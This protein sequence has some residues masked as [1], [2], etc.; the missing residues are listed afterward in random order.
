MLRRII[1]PSGRRFMTAQASQ[2]GRK[3]LL[4][5]RR[6]AMDLLG[7][8]DRGSGFSEAEILDAFGKKMIESGYKNRKNA[9]EYEEGGGT[10]FSREYRL[11][12]ASDFLL[13]ELSSH[14]STNYAAHEEVINKLKQQT[15]K[16]TFDHLVQL[17]AK[18]VAACC[19]V[20]I[21]SILYM[22]G[23]ECFTPTIK[24][25][26]Y[27][28]MTVKLAGVEKVTHHP[29][30]NSIDGDGLANAIANS[31]SAKAVAS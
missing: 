19:F 3:G 11:R 6:I 12:K 30:D 9:F 17:G 14:T 1:V 27:S 8:S 15:Q 29:S 31:L 22:L 2:Q 4:M 5:N 13:N 7:L 21:T 26:A 23:T 10:D 28:E 20:L 24:G 18:I 25:L 16:N